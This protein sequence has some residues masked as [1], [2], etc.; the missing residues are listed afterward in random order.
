MQRTL[1]SRGVSPGRIRSRT[2]GLLHCAA[3]AAA[4]LVGCSDN[5]SA[6]DGGANGNGG[7]TNSDGGGGE[8][9]ATAPEPI[10]IL[11][12]VGMG[13]VKIGMRYKEFS[14]LVGQP[15]GVMGYEHQVMAE[16]PAYG[17]KGVFA[18]GE[19][20]SLSNDAEVLSLGT[21]SK[22]AYKGEI[23]PGASRADVL[24][25]FGET[26]DIYQDYAF[27]EQGFG[28][29]YDRDGLVKQVSVFRPY[30]IRQVPPPME[31]ARTHAEGT[32]Q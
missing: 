24:K 9:K 13:D 19:A 28:V 3:L 5:T 17:L 31:S 29:E 1:W 22:G 12:G 15:D 32:G 18:S 8:A 23:V 6:D 7:S 26:P 14:E 27:H 2:V 25:L 4:L 21:L 16:F 11:P 10:A 20:S 30:K